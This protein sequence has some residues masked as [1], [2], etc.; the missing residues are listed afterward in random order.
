MHPSQQQ[1][2]PFQQIRFHE[3]FSNLLTTAGP[4]SG[5]S[6]A[7]MFPEELAPLRPVH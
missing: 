6:A 1:I 7:N 4:V 5:Y 3:G 2:G